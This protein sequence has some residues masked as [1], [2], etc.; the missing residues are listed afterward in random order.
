MDDALLNLLERIASSL[1]DLAYANQA[2]H[3]SFL[4]LAEYQ[5]NREATVEERAREL[6]TAALRRAEETHEA[7]ELGMALIGA[8]TPDTPPEEW[9]PNRATRRRRR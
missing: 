5:R 4:R 9:A 7:H 6:H 8:R 3:D 2:H 1:E